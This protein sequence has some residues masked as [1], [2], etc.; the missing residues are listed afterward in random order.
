V[1]LVSHDVNAP[2][3]EGCCTCEVILADQIP[4]MAG[5]NNTVLCGI[6]LGLR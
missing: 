3:E 1:F 2:L 4:N 6:N 5:I